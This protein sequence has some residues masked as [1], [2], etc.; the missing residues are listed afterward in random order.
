[1]ARPRKL[2]LAEVLAELEKWFGKHPFGPTV[3]ELQSL[4][5]VGSSRTVVRYL[6]ELEQA[7]LLTR[8]AGARGIL[9]KPKRAVRCVCGHQESAHCVVEHCIGCN[10]EC[11]FMEDSDEVVADSGRTG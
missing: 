5:K 6:D 2:P 9:L 3:R 10:G 8:W 11:E 1:V 4:L 7:G